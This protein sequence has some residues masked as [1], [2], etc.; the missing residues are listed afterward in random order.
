MAKNKASATA[1]LPV[2]LSQLDAH[3]DTIDFRDKMYVPT[4][5]EVPTRVTLAEYKVSY[6]SGPAILNQGKEGACTG[7]GLATVANFLLQR[8]VVVPDSKRVSARM[9]YEMARRYDEWPGE[10]YSGSSAR[11]AMKGWHKHGVCSEN[12]WPYS[13]SQAGGTLTHQ[14]AEDAAKRPLGAYF[15]VNHQDLVAMHSA[16]AEVRIVYATG[17]VH[18]GW[19]QISPQGVIPFTTKPLGGHAFAIVGYDQR[20]FWIQNSWGPSWGVGGFALITYEDWLANGT[21]VWVARLGAPMMFAEPGTKQA[22]FA[23]P[24]ARSEFSFSELRPHVISIGNNG[25][26]RPEGTFGN[27]EEDVKTIF[28]QD[29]ARLTNGWEKKRLLLYAH[30]GLV[31]ENNAL[32]RVEDYR[33]PLLEAEVYP[34]AF[35]WKT[36]FWTTLKNILNDA[37]SRRRPE[38]FLDATKDFLLNRLDDTLEPIARPLGKPMWSEMKQNALLATEAKDG[39]AKFVLS[40]VKRLLASDPSW[41]IHIAGHSAGSIFMAPVVEWFSAQGLPVRTLTLWAPACTME[42][43]HKYYMPALKDKTIGHFS[44]FTLKDAAEQ[45]D[46]CARIYNKSLLYLVS[47]AFEEKPRFFFADGEPLLGM[48]QFIIEDKTFQTPPEKELRKKNPALVPVLGLKN[49]EW[50]RS[51]NGLPE[52]DI[53]SSHSR[54]HGDFDDDKATVLATLARITGASAAS[55]PNKSALAFPPSAAALHDCRKRLNRE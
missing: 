17:T 41:E 22:H 54:R 24:N 16:L 8:R 29:L 28:R 26:L 18:E 15:R 11:G 21:D 31:G 37:L 30:G 42:L 34:L 4:L 5:V 51:P 33:K 45:D 7:F 40:E 10:K 9:F 19:S 35:I 12:V 49:A 47:N 55:T 23:S 53:K 20:G 50:I 14:R 25:V 39:G 2:A 6:P 43:F 52:G 3:P 48:E 27:S 44:L 36:D 32:Q 46:D 38:G 1:G 13:V